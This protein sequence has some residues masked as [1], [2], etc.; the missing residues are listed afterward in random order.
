MSAILILFFFLVFVVPQ[1]EPVFKDLGNRLNGG[2]A[3]V[4]SASSWLRANL[5]LFFGSCI[6]IV[7]AAWVI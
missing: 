5:Q 1:F 6:V 2:A 3:F 7:L 4:L